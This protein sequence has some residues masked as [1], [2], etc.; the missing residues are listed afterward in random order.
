MNPNCD[1]CIALPS[2][3]VHLR[4][5]RGVIVYNV[6]EDGADILAHDVRLAGQLLGSCKQLQTLALYKCDAVGEQHPCVYGSLADL[7]CNTQL[8]VLALAAC[9]SGARVP[10]FPFLHTLHLFPP[11][12]EDYPPALQHTFPHLCRLILGSTWEGH[13]VFLTCD[14]L[15]ALEHLESLWVA[16]GPETFDFEGIDDLASLCRCPKLRDLRLCGIHY[17]DFDDLLQAVKALQLQRVQLQD[18]EIDEEVSARALEIAIRAASGRG[19]EME[20]EV[21]DKVHPLPCLLPDWF[22]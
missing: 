8:E 13:E 3:A 21:S 17:L 14:Q 1:A 6:E 15:P 7:S 9:E 12:S 2:Q 18:C 20:V 19:T 5:L 11:S 16:A 22:G 4:H 10:V